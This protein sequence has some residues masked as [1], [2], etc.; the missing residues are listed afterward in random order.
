MEELLTYIRLTHRPYE[1]E[2]ETYRGV[3]DDTIE[4]EI[5]VGPNE[6]RRVVGNGR[7]GWGSRERLHGEKQLKSTE[8]PRDQNF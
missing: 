6:L 8:S 3:R 1:N 2:N 7:G 5:K 4:F